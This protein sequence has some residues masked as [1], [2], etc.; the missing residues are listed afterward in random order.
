V[1][2]SLLL[3]AAIA[4]SKT[5]SILVNLSSLILSNLSLSE[6]DTKH[7]FI[8]SYRATLREHREAK[9]L[10]KYGESFLISR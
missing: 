2:V 7:Q 9:N 1:I 10:S 6:Y 8:N 3:V 5:E 4:F